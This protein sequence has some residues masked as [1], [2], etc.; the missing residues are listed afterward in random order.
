MVEP[1]DYVKA[2]DTDLA[3][4]RHN[5]SVF[6]QRLRANPGKAIVL[7]ALMVV[8]GVGLLLVSHGSWTPVVLMAAAAFGIA[9]WLMAATFRRS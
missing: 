5:R 8:L 9:G 7:A 3:A 1:K 4:Q 2:R 6:V